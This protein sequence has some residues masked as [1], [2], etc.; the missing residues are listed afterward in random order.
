MTYITLFNNIGKI[1]L[2]NRILLHLYIL[3][4]YICKRCNYKLYIRTVLLKE[5]LNIIFLLRKRRTKKITE[6]GQIGWESLHEFSYQH[7]INIKH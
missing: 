5:L 2:S 1:Y 3:I 6:R 4:V 7:F